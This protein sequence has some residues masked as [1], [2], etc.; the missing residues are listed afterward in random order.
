MRQDNFL[1]FLTL[2]NEM[3]NSILYQPKELFNDDI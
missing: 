1:S 2:F 3:S